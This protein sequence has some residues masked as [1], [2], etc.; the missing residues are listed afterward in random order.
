MSIPLAAIL[1]PTL[2]RR[3]RALVRV[4]MRL[5]AL[6]AS[7]HPDPVD[8][9]MSALRAGRWIAVHQCELLIA[10]AVIWGAIVMSCAEGSF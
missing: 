9:S 3:P 4:L 5:A 6:W 8:R 2:P 1:I 7:A 10:F